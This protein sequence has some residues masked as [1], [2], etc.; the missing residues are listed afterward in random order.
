M[1]MQRHCL[2]VLKECWHSNHSTFAN[3]VSTRLAKRIEHG[4]GQYFNH[5]WDNTRENLQHFSASIHTLKSHLSFWLSDTA[6]H[7][8]FYC[9]IS[10]FKRKWSHC[11][12]NI[13]SCRRTTCTDVSKL[14]RCVVLLASLFQKSTRTKSIFYTLLLSLSSNL[15]YT[16]RA[17]TNTQTHVRPTKEKKNH[18]SKVAHTWYS[19]TTRWKKIYS[20]KA[21]P[22]WCSATVHRGS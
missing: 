20:S 3:S 18:W 13:E 9:L 16:T 19:A 14:R 2:C 8:R 6:Q 15:Y 7:E 17:F 4:E 1:W 12:S 22:I 21:T 11:A 5:S 10:N